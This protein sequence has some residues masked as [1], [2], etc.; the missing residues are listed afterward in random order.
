MLGPASHSHS[1]NSFLF[2]ILKSQGNPIGPIWPSTY[3]WLVSKSQSVQTWLLEHTPINLGWREDSCQWRRK[4]C[5]STPQKL[6]ILLINSLLHLQ[7]FI[8]ILFIWHT[9][10]L[11][12]RKIPLVILCQLSHTSYTVKTLP[13]ISLQSLDT[14]RACSFASIAGTH[15]T[16]HN[17]LLW[18]VW[19]QQ[20]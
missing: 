13:F 14:F 9:Q 10:Q 7:L 19:P 4:P 3:V 18:G 1:S 17:S 5:K 6:S 2:L 8:S 12:G 15:G 20:G 16:L 11:C